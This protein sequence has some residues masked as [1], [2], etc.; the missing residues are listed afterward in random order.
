MHPLNLIRKKWLS[1]RYGYWNWRDKKG[2]GFWANDRP[3]LFITVSF[4]SDRTLA[5]L[6]VDFLMT[7]AGDIK[8]GT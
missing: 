3:L 5:P 2:T 7:F 6:L 1:L 4:L 8:R